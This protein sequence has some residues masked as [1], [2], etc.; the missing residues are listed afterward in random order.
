M[1][2]SCGLRCGKVWLGE[3]RFCRQREEPGAIEGLLMFEHAEDGV[4]EL[5]HDGDQSLHFGF[6]ARDEVQ[7]EG[8]Q[9]RFMADGDPSADG[10]ACR[11]HG[12][13]GGCRFY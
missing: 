6:A 10:R 13:G 11:E 4:Q 12:A 1:R 7:V 2:V 5:A 9:V 3:E 8:A